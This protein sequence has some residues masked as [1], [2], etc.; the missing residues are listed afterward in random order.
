M[1][2][3]ASLFDIGR[4]GLAAAQ[5]GL[6][7]VSHNIA[8][9][10]T[11][12]YARQQ[13]V[14]EAATP[15]NVK[16]GQL[17]TGV[18][19]SQI[20]RSVDTFVENQLTTSHE[21]VGRYDA[22]RAA[23]FRVQAVLGDGGES[24]ITASLNQF[25][26]AVQ[27]VA[28]SPADTTARNV[29]LA[30]ANILTGQLN[31]AA[32]ELATMR[33]ALNRQVSQT[34]AEINDRATQIA[35]LNE[36]IVDAETRGQSA[37]DLRDRR[38]QLVNETAERIEVTTL[39]DT[40]GNLSV[41]VGRGQALVSVGT[42]R[43]LVA[44][45]D[46]GNDGM[47]GVG[48]DTGGTAYAAIGSLITSG[49]LK[50]LLEARDTTIP[51]VQASLDKLAASLTNDVNLVH[52][53][54]YGLDGSTGRNFFSALSVS[55]AADADNSGTAEIGSGTIAANSLLTL[56]DYA[57]TF[58]GAST[59]EIRDTTTGDYIRG[60]YTGTAVTAPTAD[61]PI[62][63]TSGSND[64][65]VVQVDGTTSGTITLTAGSYA[66]GA[67]LAEEL[68][69]RIN[70][71]ATLAAAGRTVTV[72]WDATGGRFVVRSDAETAAS[73]VNVT[74]GSARA[75]LGLSSGTSTAAS[76]TYSTPQT[77]VV[78]GLSVTLTGATSDGDVF[79][80]NS[81]EGAST[82]FDV[83]LASPNAVAAA[84]TRSGVPND[85]TAAQG[86]A[87]LRSAS[88]GGLGDATYSAFFAATVSDLGAAAQKAD[89]DLKAQDAQKQQ[90]ES[91]RSEISGVS[92]DEE[93]VSMMQY[94]RAFEASAR[95]ISIT[96]E[97]LQTLINLR[98]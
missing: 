15:Q 67:A 45:E 8:N 27:D 71:D 97:V 74:S 47:V 44:M 46:A 14:Q 35:R 83:A 87:A 51:D 54:G 82:A 53:A 86:L 55:A 69:T 85:G 17:G 20:K 42:A 38:Q 81:Y 57:I 61:A 4:S 11:P 77:F 6:T 84:A 16:G 31:Q 10:N 28:S 58:T 91:F 19:V 23:L 49:R 93:L 37:N 40:Q 56:H 12:G 92:L 52:R 76:G 9:I 70:A 80:F 41:F 33:T 3:I 43:A 24:G 36:Q 29:L 5:K 95:I 48:Y 62:T 72:S 68:Q 39:E 64:T 73:R 89:R 63:I 65:L 13:A 88:I 96:D 21:S 50:G 60:N 30:K 66:S 94:Q 59:Y 34:I 7:V 26:N 18:T 75:T 2:G 25:F 78:D 22:Y 79:T 98:R 32:S 90:M 1:S